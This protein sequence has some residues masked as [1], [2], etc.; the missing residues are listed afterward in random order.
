MVHTPRA[1]LREL[2]S[3]DPATA[4][5]VAG[6]LDLE[7]QAARAADEAESARAHCEEEQKKLD[8]FR[9]RV[10]A[11]EQAGF[12]VGEALQYV[13]GNAAE[14]RPVGRE[15]R[16]T[17]TLDGA[18]YPGGH[19][20]PRHYDVELSDLV[21]A[22]VIDPAE[23]LVARY[24][25]TEY[26]ADIAR[27]GSMNVRGH[28]PASTLSGAGRLITAG[29]VNGWGFWGVIRGGKWVSLKQVRED[30]L[31]AQGRGAGQES[32]SRRRDIENA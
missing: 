5:V 13:R 29:A 30:Y 21:R 25:R 9:G 31:G 1:R 15:G 6:L 27:D 19:R 10:E 23:P 16:V 20:D 8:A 14:G 12:G 7:E 18:G 32:A 28:G 2:Q 26:V 4:A 24:K 22:R 11:L 17:P 3:R